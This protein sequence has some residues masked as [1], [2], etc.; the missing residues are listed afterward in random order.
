[1]RQIRSLAKSGC[2]LVRVAVPKAADTKAFAR[3]A[4][5]SPVPLI[6]DVHFSAARALEAIEGGAAKV[7]IN[8]GNIK[9]KSD[10]IRIIEAAKAHNVAIR[11]GV[12]E[13]SIRDLKKGDTRPEKRVGL[14]LREMKS[15]VKIFDS[16]NFTSLVLSA[17]AA[18]VVRTIEINRLLSKTFN[19]PLHLGLT[20][21]GLEEDASV[22]SAAAMGSLLSEGIGDT[23]RI[24]I[25]GNPVREVLIAKQIL[26]AMG[27]REPEGPSL[28]VCPT[29]GR[30]QVDVIKLAKQVKRAVKKVELPIKIAVMGCIVNGPGEAADAD[31]A[32]CAG[33]GK[34][35]IYRG[36]EKVKTVPEDKLMG[37]MLA[38]I[39]KMSFEQF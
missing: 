21:A 38:L 2:G 5:R 33:S 3:L 25:A 7:R 26:T 12:N 23:I 4:E 32:I 39:E 14:M 27:L 30:C 9:D 18:N 22:S 24:S 16:K 17:K 20:H 35:F 10:I 31:I 1:L 28:I 19:S 34:G 15:Y 13:A 8:P 29:C 6:A 11:I 37:E 36:G